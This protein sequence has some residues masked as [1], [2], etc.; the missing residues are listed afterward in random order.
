[1]SLVASVCY[2]P[3][4]KFGPNSQQ[5]EFTGAAWLPPQGAAWHLR[6]RIFSL[7]SKENGVL[8]PMPHLALLSFGY[9]LWVGALANALNFQGHPPL[10]ATGPSMMCTQIPALDRLEIGWILRL[11]WILG[12][13]VSIKKCS[14][15]VCIWSRCWDI[16]SY[17]FG[18]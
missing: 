8:A 17:I 4:P 9:P 11:Q 6:I 16:F 15:N 1:M 18:P 12:H 7:S 2:D 10:G 3:V 13:N 14:Q 5:I